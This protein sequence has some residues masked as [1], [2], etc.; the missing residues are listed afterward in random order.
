MRRITALDMQR[1]L[2]QVDTVI[3]DLK[4]NAVFSP[5][6]EL[7]HYDS[8]IQDLTEVRKKYADVMEVT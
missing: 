6:D 4:V 3:T 1:A 2:K 5:A 8:I 7:E